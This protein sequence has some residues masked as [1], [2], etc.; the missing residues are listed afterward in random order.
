MYIY[1]YVCILICIYMNLYRSDTL[2]DRRMS[3]RRPRPQPQCVL[4][5]N[6]WTC[7]AAPEPSPVKPQT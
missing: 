1:M 4:D 7:P 6:A 5:V 2:C 3:F